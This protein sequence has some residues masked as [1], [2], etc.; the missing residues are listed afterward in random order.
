MNDYV[1][2]VTAYQLNMNVHF[3]SG[4]LDYSSQTKYRSQGIYIFYRPSHLYDRGQSPLR[5][6]G[7]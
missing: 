7:P 2:D 4:G 6:K 1:P 3:N 5:Q